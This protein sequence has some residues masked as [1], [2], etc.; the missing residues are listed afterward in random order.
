M[1]RRKLLA[2]TVA[3]LAGLGVGAASIPFIRS[4][5]PTAR[6]NQLTTRI[7]FPKLLPGQL[8][9]AQLPW[10]GLVYVLYRTQRMLDGLGKFSGLLDP[11]STGSVQPTL[12]ENEYRSINPEI[13]VVKAE[14]TH[15]G[16]NVS[17][18][19]PDTL[20]FGPGK[21]HGCFY[22]PC[23]LCVFDLAGRV[24]TGVPADRNLEVPNYEFISDKEIEIELR[25]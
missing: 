21:E 7:E 2:R 9:T 8:V 25:T 6:A 16:C 18:L 1:Q 4:C 12:A 17:Y 24:V 15:L 3:L 14:C 5:K 13:L 22:C 23:H 20:G 10:G 19:T 11:D